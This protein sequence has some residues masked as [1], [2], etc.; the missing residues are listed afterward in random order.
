MNEFPSID[1]RE[2]EGFEE[3]LPLDCSDGKRGYILFSPKGDALR[4]SPGAY[5]LLRELRNATSLSA[6][7]KTLQTG[8]SDSL[9]RLESA[10]K[11]ILKRLDDIQRRSPRARLPWGF[12]IRW[13]LVS[14]DL[15]SRIASFASVVYHPIS[16][17]LVISG[18]LAAISGLSKNQ[19]QFGISQ[20]NILQAYIL[21][22]VSLVIHEFGH[23]AACARYGAR[24]SEIGFAI[25]LIYPAFYSD[26]N[27][28]WKLHRWKRVI[29][30]VG[31]S[32]FQ[33]AFGAALYGAF[34]VTHWVPLRVAFTMILYMA[35]F[36]LNP[37][38]KF[39][40]YWIVV[41]ALGVP[42]LSRQP[43][44]ITKYFGRRLLGLQTESLN[45]PLPITL[46]L[47]VYTLV[48]NF[49][50]TVFIL[51]VL[52]SLVASFLRLYVLITGMLWEIF[53]GRIPSPKEFYSLTIAVY[54]SVIL[55]TVLY[56]I[57][58][59]I[60]NAVKSTYKKKNTT[61]QAE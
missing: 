27:S 20:S 15:V 22:L 30:D 55:C 9:I 58:L 35:L 36:C 25:Y 4:V 17:V 19:F 21:F 50:W 12:W 3:E 38:F 5:G 28:C 16:I 45:W 13:P 14:Q 33:L 26:V 18:I 60:K 42:N 32:Y 54:L 10:G 23:A 40:G 56:Q 6:T 7:G 37:I 29:V 47:I 53:S 34:S 51:R 52:P 46:G 39:D 48:S 8:P 49:V 31:G 43:W 44:H 11:E 1:L 61:T 2:Y 57:V 41:D 24:P 59:L